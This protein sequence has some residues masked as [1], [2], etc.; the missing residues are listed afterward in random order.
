MT[1]PMTTTE[2]NAA[3]N[4]II[5]GFLEIPMHPDHSC[6]GIFND[7]TKRYVEALQYHSSWDSLHG[8]WGRARE[9]IGTWAELEGDDVKETWE[10]SE[11]YMSSA[12]VH[13]DIA[14]AF[15]CLTDIITYYNDNKTNV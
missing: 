14:E 4:R 9:V 10:W 6:A 3:K 11:K 12:M 13:N 15:E 5:A 1:H 2:G 7:G 8:A